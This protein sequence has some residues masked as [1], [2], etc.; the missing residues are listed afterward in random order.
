[1]QETVEQLL[2]KVKKWEFGSDEDI[3]ILDMH[4]RYVIEK[5][6]KRKNKTLSYV[7]GA[8]L[9]ALKKRVYG[10]TKID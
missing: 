10:T 8:L 9:E 7:E 6:K 4:K 1:M 2:A 5:K 3:M